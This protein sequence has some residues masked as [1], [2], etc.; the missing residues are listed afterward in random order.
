VVWTDG[1][2]DD[3]GRGIRATVF[4]NGGTVVSVDALVNST[5]A[6]D[7]DA[8][9]VIGL[10]DGGFLVAWEDDHAGVTRAQRFEAD[11]K[12]LGSE[13][14]IFAGTGGGAPHMALLSDGRVVFSFDRLQGGD[15]DV[16]SAV[17]DPR[18]DDGAPAASAGNDA[19]TA[20]AQ[21]SRLSGLA[22]NDVL[23][24]LDGN[25]RLDGGAGKDSL[26]GG[27]GFDRLGG[28]RGA[29][30]LTGGDGGDA[31]VF[32]AVAESRPGKGRDHIEDFAR[33]DGDHIDLSGIDANMR[34]AGD[35]DFHFVD[36]DLKQSF[37]AYH[38]HHA[39]G[40]WAGALRVSAQNVVQGDVNGDGKADFEIVVHG[41]HLTKAD[42]IV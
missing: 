19:L 5:T 15:W 39:K 3:S 9:S 7:Q 27:S 8:A 23:T 10:A 1:A 26:F 24:G 36:G 13:F 14:N 42:F 29:D 17:F 11:G 22:G 12:A 6:G 30:H 25:D 40:D 32:L 21:G 20:L 33:G 41:D 37:A 18:A 28:G 38:N 31:F 2:G 4:D 16:V 35:Q 34:R